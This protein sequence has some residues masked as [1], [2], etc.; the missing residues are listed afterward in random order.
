MVSIFELNDKVTYNEYK[1]TAVTPY[2]GTYATKTGS[3]ENAIKAYELTK[4]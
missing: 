4:W 3:W 2:Q 1:A